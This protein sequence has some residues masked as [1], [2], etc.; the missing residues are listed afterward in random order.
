MVDVWEGSSND[1]KV[2]T[3]GWFIVKVVILET[4]FPSSDFLL[5]VVMHT[6]TLRKA[7]QPPMQLG[8]VEV[9]MYP[10]NQYLPRG[11]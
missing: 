4:S 9:V 5:R 8:T 10:V 2:G 1:G 6:A 11:L 7:L 3:L